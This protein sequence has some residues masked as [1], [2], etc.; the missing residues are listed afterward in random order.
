MHDP[1][2]CNDS[3]DPDVGYEKNEVLDDDQIKA[4]CFIAK[5]LGTPDE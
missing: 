5:I 1:Y 2:P 3:G 4:L